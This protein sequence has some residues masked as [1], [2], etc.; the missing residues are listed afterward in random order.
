MFIINPGLQLHYWN[1]N[2]AR[3]FESPL[4]T[5]DSC[6]TIYM[7]C[8]SAYIRGSERNSFSW[9]LETWISALYGAW[10]LLLLFFWNHVQWVYFCGIINKRQHW[11][12]DRFIDVATFDWFCIHMQIEY[13]GNY[14][15]VIHAFLMTKI[16]CVLLIFI[17]SPIF[18]LHFY[19]LV[20][21]LMIASRLLKYSSFKY[22]AYT[23]L[24]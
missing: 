8:V 18:N 15:M 3:L 4:I 11:P 21:S 6:S 12:M 7:Q 10:D 23:V 20:Y 5:K 22:A 16:H 14:S 24:F 1:S 13:N 19:A 2:K 9:A 17:T